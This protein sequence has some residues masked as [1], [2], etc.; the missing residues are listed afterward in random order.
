MASVSG[1][2]SCGSAVNVA[3]K[4]CVSLT[5]CTRSG[6]S[7]NV[8]IKFKAYVYVTSQW[9]S[10]SLAIYVNGTEYTV[11]NSN[12]G[13]NKTTVN[14]K[15]YT[16]E[17][18][19]TLA[20]SGSST[21]FDIGVNGTAWNPSSAKANFTFT[22]SD[23]PA[24]TYTITFNPNG[25]TVSTTSKTVTAGSTYGTLP[26]PER[27]NA[28]NYSYSF[29]GWY[30]AASGGTR[31]QSTTTVSL[32][33]N[34]TL[35]AHWTSTL[36]TSTCGVPTS[37]TITNST[38]NNVTISCKV[39]SNGTGNNASGVDFYV[40]FDGSTPST[41]NYHH[42]V[43]V[44]GS[45]SA[46]A[47]TSINLASY[48]QSTWE[49]YFGTDCIGAVKAVARTRGAAGASYYSGVTS[50]ASNTSVTYKGAPK[51]PAVI[52]SPKD[53]VIKGKN[54]NDS[55]YVAWSAATAGVNDTIG[56]YTV[57]VYN[58]STNA[59][60][61]SYNTGTTKYKYIP[62]SVFAAGNTYY[63]KVRAT[64]AASSLYVDSLASGLAEFKNI[65]SFSMPTITVANAGT[66]PTTNINGEEAFL[67]IGTG[68]VLKISWPKPVASNN[69]VSSY[70]IEIYPSE[71]DPYYTEG[72]NGYFNYE[73]GGNVNEVYI[74]AAELNPGGPGIHKFTIYFYVNSKFGSYYS[75]NDSDFVEYTFVNNC[76]GA[77]IKLD[78]EHGYPQPVMR[79]AVAFVKD[80]ASGEWKLCQ[81]AFHKDPADEWKTGDISYEVLMDQNGE[82]ITDS[83]NKPIYTL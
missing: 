29:A 59:L 26:T 65:T 71:N 68:D 10:N 77:Y 41:S 73:Y 28:N 40:T 8:T 64:S 62:N 83:S 51:T 3:A 78:R 80:Q 58:A 53:K 25:G 48:S 35:Y 52:T 21:T 4:V 19:L 24:K 76:H 43:Y 37:L 6:Y 31:I 18:T 27:A 56:S 67:N 69:E 54:S 55:C 16:S 72:A 33:A 9:S 34:Q 49:A 23:A 39:G 42:T 7:D 12:N 13:A 2:Q 11:F 57:Y 75:A 81:G 74:P 61:T 38:T 70:Y 82:I 30:T 15:Y 60:V 20:C 66:V 1:E 46:N 22:L 17:I 5:S 79:R 63:F 32:T 14:N 47:S 50:V 45:A 44:T 36:L